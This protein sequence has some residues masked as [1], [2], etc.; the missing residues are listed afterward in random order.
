MQV[1]TAGEYAQAFLASRTQSSIGDQPVWLSDAR[2]AALDSAQRVG[3]PGPRDEAWKYTRLNAIQ[4]TLYALAT[5]IDDVDFDVC[6]IVAENRI[7]NAVALLVFINGHYQ[8]R[9]STVADLPPGLCIVSLKQALNETPDQVAACFGRLAQIRDSAFTALNVAGAADGALLKVAPDVCI[10]QPVQLLFISAPQ[11]QPISAHPR[12]IVHAQ[13]RSAVSIIEHF[14]ATEDHRYLTNKVTEIRADQAATV[15]HYLLQDEGINAHHIGTVEVY[16][17]A[18]SHVESHSCAFG[19]RLSRTAINIHQHKPDASCLV[20]G[21]FV[22]DGRQYVDFHTNIEHHQPRGSSHEY[23]NGILKGRACG[24]FDGRVYV[25]AH[26]QQADAHLSNHNLLLSSDAEVN[27]K[28]QLEIYADD[29]KCSH[30]ATVGQLDEQ[31]LFYLRSR[32]LTAATARALL[33]VGFGRSI[34]GRVDCASIRQ[35]LYA[36]LVHQISNNDS[37]LELLSSP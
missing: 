10:E 25:H 7:A 1:I 15:R 22:V 12:V 13:P 8:A 28:P 35:L 24:V 18:H 11:A 6:S 23:F 2:Q 17:D 16:Q 5:D 20:N 26:A 29:V 3:F 9:Y 34:I 21:L 27:T 37:L 19:A 14:V 30:G 32:G 36:R 31:Q 4:Q 33:T